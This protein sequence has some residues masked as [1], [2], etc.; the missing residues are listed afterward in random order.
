MVEEQV[1]CLAVH[2]RYLPQVLEAYGKRCTKI[3]R[4]VQRLQLSDTGVSGGISLKCNVAQRSFSVYNSTWVGLHPR[5]YPTI[6]AISVLPIY[7]CIP[8]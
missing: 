3:D 6:E 8:Q 7:L 1:S 5:A 4:F 2:F